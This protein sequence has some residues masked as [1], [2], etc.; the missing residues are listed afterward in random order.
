MALLGLK[1]MALSGNAGAWVVDDV[2]SRRPPVPSLYR[3]DTA[4]LPIG[5]ALSRY[6]RAEILSLRKSR[7][8]GSSDATE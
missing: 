6:R 4:P 2:P 7:S 8:L 5:F 1:Y 3:P